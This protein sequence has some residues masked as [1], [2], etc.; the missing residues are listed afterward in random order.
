MVHEA[1]ARLDHRPRRVHRLEKLDD[2]LL[3]VQQLGGALEDHLLGQVD[4]RGLAFRE[5][6]QA[7]AEH[8]AHDDRRRHGIGARAARR[9]GRTVAA[10]EQLIGD[11]LL[12]DVEDRLA[13]EIGRASCRERV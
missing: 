12:V 1:L 13:S 2:D 4:E 5:I 11:H 6:V 9:I 3:R 10:V 7:E 8:A